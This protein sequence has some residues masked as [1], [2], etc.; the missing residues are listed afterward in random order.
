MNYPPPK[1]GVPN[2]HAQRIVQNVVARRACVRMCQDRPALVGQAA[3]LAFGIEGNIGNG[4][5]ADLLDKQGADVRFAGAL[6]AKRRDAFG[7]DGINVWGEVSGELE[8]HIGIIGDGQGRMRLSGCW[9]AVCCFI[10]VVMDGNS[11]HLSWER[12]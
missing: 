10:A 1:E 9:G 12:P 3:V 7:N 6:H 4:V 11:F 8:D 2:H 5:A